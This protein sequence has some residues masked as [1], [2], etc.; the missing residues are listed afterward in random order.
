[1]RRSRKHVWFFVAPGAELLDIA[2]PW[3]VLQHANGVLGRTAYEV[4]LYGPGGPELRTRHGLVIGGVR[5]LPSKVR[6][7]PEV[8]VI[9]GGSPATPLPGAEMRLVRWLRRHHRR[10]PTIVSICT[11]AVVLGEA[12]ILDGRRATT[13][14]RV[15]DELRIRFPA[16]KVVDDG[17][18][19]HDGNLWT[20]AGITAGIDLT[21][22]LVEEDHGHAVAMTVAKELVLFL[23]R[24]GRQAQFSATLRRQ[25]KVPSTR[26]DIYA[27]VLEHLDEP[28]PVER[29]ADGTGMSPRTLSRWCRTHLDESPAELVRRVRVDEARRLLE[30]TDL[31]VKDIS[32][33][34]GLGDVSTM[35]RLFTQHLG[36]TPA[37]YRER[38][39]LA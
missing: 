28:L 24:S 11:G 34:T 9:A 14:W 33:R 13:H 38:F 16:A 10:I 27:F 32:A 18:F 8:T 29:L 4:E 15:L 1:M 7:P 6:R 30:E 36:V 25:D 17:I 31:P 35:W 22:S 12:G 21:L 26:Q 5:P 2:G 39:S 37:E 23:R 3:E 20:S 19:V